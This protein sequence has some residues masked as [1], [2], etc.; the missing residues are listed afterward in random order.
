MNY[1]QI[2]QVALSYSDREDSDTLNMMDNFLRIVESR[3]NRLLDVREMSQRSIMYAETDKEYYGLPKCFSGIRSIEVYNVDTPNSKTSLQYLSPE[4]MNAFIGSG[5]VQPK[6]TII[7]DQFRIYPAQIDGCIFQIVY[8]GDLPALSDVTPENFMSIDYPDVYIFGLLIEINSYA[9]DPATA[10]L[11]ES[12][13]MGAINDLKLADQIDR[14]S[15]NSL[16]IR[17][18]P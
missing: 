8:Y 12:R 13:F 1:N 18:I 10:Q 7:A 11:W 9:K 16:E 5:G 15:G 3:M 17:A 2:K 4:M 6:Y 14:W